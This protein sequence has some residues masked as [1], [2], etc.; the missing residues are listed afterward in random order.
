[1][2]CQTYMLCRGV[3]YQTCTLHK[4]V[5]TEPA[6]SMGVHPARI[7][8]SIPWHHLLYRLEGPLAKVR[9]KQPPLRK[10]LTLFSAVVA[11]VIVKKGCYP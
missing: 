5:L 3:L 2:L 7:S 11:Q 1:M 9:G 10:I 8:D 6:H 4:G